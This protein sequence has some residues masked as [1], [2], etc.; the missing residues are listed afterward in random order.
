[1]EYPGPMI[2]STLH[3]FRE[4]KNI[5]LISIESS[6]NVGKQNLNS[7]EEYY[8]RINY[9][10][11]SNE[12]F[13]TVKAVYEFEISKI[14]ESRDIIE[15]GINDLAENG[16]YYCSIKYDQNEYYLATLMRDPNGIFQDKNYYMEYFSKIY[17]KDGLFNKINLHKIPKV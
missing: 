9:I 17:N 10:M 3:Y 4:N 1:M 15:I 16:L 5:K 13:V 11:K 7:L 12:I 8:F 6:N 14:D 2:D